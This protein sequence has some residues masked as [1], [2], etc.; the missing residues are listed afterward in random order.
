[1]PEQLAG[2]QLA[3]QEGAVEAMEWLLPPGTERPEGLGHQ[4]LAGAGLPQNEHRQV[5]GRQAGEPLE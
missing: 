3:P 4:F 1:V 5:G 2:A